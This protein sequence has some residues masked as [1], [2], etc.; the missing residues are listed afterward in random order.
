[1]NTSP[2]YAYVTPVASDPV[3]VFSPREPLALVAGGALSL[4]A[5][6]VLLGLICA[7]ILGRRP[8]RGRRQRRAKR[9]RHDPEIED[10]RVVL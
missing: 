7:A 1:V 2:W 5:A 9:G 4:V 6:V 8:S 10:S 3:G